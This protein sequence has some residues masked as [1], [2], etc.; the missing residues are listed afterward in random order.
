MIRSICEDT[1]FFGGRLNDVLE[2]RV[3]VSACFRIVGADRTN[4]KA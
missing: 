4:Y 1:T 2:D 3:G